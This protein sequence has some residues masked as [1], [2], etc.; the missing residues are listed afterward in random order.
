MA[1]LQLQTLGEPTQPGVSVETDTMENL[2]RKEQKEEKDFPGG[3]TK[4][5]IVPKRL[6]NEVWEDRER[7]FEDYDGMKEV[8]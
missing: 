6:G 8:M 1:R 3:R 5:E 4:G 7:I 2:W